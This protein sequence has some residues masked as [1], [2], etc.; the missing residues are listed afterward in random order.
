MTTRDRLGAEAPPLAAASLEAI[1]AQNP[2]GI[3]V[4]DGNG[5]VTFANDVAAGLLGA[6]L[7]ALHGRPLGFVALPGVATEIDTVRADG[8]ATVAELRVSSIDWQGGTA[9][10]ATLRDVTTRRRAEEGLQLLLRLNELVADADSFDGALRIAVDTLCDTLEWTFGHVWLPSDGRTLSAADISAGASTVA[11]RF[12]A[13]TS[14]VRFGRGEELPGRAWER[15]AP[16]WVEDFEAESDL[17]RGD[18]AR[19]LRLRSA[20]AFPVL[21]DDETRAVVELFSLQVRPAEDHTV[22]L[23]RALSTQLGVLVR[24]KQAEDA[25]ARVAVSTATRNHDLG[26]LVATLEQTNQDLDVFAQRASHDLASPLTIAAGLARTLADLYGDDLD[27]LGRELLE[28][29]VSATDRMRLLI[30]SVLA[31]A[32]SG[33]EL[34]TA[35]IDSRIVVAETVAMMRADIDA[36][37]GQVQLGSLPVLQADPVQF[38]EV[39]QNLLTN[40]IKY[41]SPGRP[42][43]IRIS[44]ERDDADWTFRIEDNGVGIPDGEHGSV[45]DIF[46]RGAGAAAVTGSGI[47]LAVCRRVIE[48]HNGRIWAE[49]TPGGGTA[50]VFA[51]PV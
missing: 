31:F 20:V 39:I 46:K 19:E 14:S 42:L 2:D 17:A 16:T 32:R 41:R 51:L 21:V 28:R 9:T 48:R 47:G 50:F 25:L 24:R 23:F 40:A 8:R 15:G 4:V 5:V 27:D 22:S 3:I 10:L 18:A 29:M 44:A 7:Q 33:G 1:I 13:L 38:A 11:E 34:Q 30:D 26:A 36:V 35:S 6:E 43:R 49:P 37:G 45:F 12:R